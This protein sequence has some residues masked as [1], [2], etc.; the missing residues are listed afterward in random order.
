MSS[1]LLQRDSLRDSFASRTLLFP[2]LPE[3]IGVGEDA[4]AVS[5]SMAPRTVRR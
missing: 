5:I 4:I 1:M 2:M 3:L